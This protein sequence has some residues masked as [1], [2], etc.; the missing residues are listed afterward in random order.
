[1]Q[2]PVGEVYQSC[3]PSFEPHCGFSL[4]EASVECTE[5]C[6]CPGGQLRF[7]GKCVE[8]DA[9]PCQLRNKTF[10][11]HAH[12][13]RDCN[14]CECS[15]G[16]WQCSAETCGARCSA[17]GD[18]HYQTFDQRRFDFMGKCAYTLMQTANVSI[19]AENVACSGQISADIDVRYAAATDGKG[20]AV[21]QPSCTKSV[22]IALL[23]GD[24]VERVKL[25]QGR[26]VFVNGAPLPTIPSR[27]FGGRLKIREASSTVLSVRLADG[28]KVWWDGVTNVYID[29]PAAYRNQ[30][31]GLCGTFNSNA[32]DDFLTPE[33][34]TETAVEAF[35]NKWRTRESCGQV[36]SDAALP[37][38]CQLNVENRARARTACA[39]LRSEAF[40]SCDWYVG[41]EQFHADCM[42]DM[43]SCRTANVR[44]CLCP[45]LQ[46]YAS[47]CAQAGVPLQWRHRVA[48]CAVQCPAGQ[49]FEECGDSCHRTCADLH[50]E[51]DDDDIIVDVNNGVHTNDVGPS[52]TSSCRSACVE[53]CR[54]PRGQL[55]N[56]NGECV[57]TIQCACHFDGRP[58]SAG[59][60]EVRAGRRHLELCTCTNARW[61]CT[62]A[63]E[64]DAAQYPAAADKRKECAADPTRE[65][66]ECMPELVRTCKNMHQYAIDVRSVASVAA[67]A[68]ECRSGCVCRADRVWDSFK[69][70]CV[71]PTQCGC[72][73]GGKS[74]ETGQQIRSDCNTCECSSLGEWRCTDEPCP[75]T[76]VAWGD[77]H[78]ESF[79]G[80]DFDFQGVCSY[81]LSKGVLPETDDAFAISI[82]NVQCGTLG[83][84]CSKSVTIALLGNTRETITLDS[85][86]DTSTQPPQS[87]PNMLVYNVGLFTVVELRSLDVQVKWDRGTRVYIRLGVR[88]RRHVQG[89]CGNYNGDAEDDLKTPAAGV[90][91]NPTLFG[92]SWK[93]E[94]FCERPQEQI[95]TCAA[96]PERKLWAQ[97][98]C[99]ILKSPVFE[100]CHA[101]VSVDRFMRRCVYDSCGCDQ[102]GDCHCLCTAIAAY[103]HECA[104]KGVPIR[105]RTPQMCRKYYSLIRSSVDRRL[106]L[107]STNFQ[108]CNV[109][110]V[111]RNT[112]RVSARP[113]RRPRVT[114]AHLLA[115]TPCSNANR[116]AASKVVR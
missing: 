59:Y 40:A 81:L 23:N 94:E 46:A 67:P 61:S 3:G 105:W 57:P 70:L 69:Q 111:A 43:C 104:A 68:G 86:K 97:R 96:H 42:Y 74:F 28:L 50:A 41:V 26:A 95:D 85:A 62:K 83:V 84:T 66:V 51:D 13:R 33:G 58:Y 17:I 107:N 90:E 76:C 93:L 10:P 103:A 19:E 35:A 106:Y 6:F 63:S 112:H 9:C 47:Q 14:T 54:C 16:K 115:L 100:R 55:L 27:L 39:V 48:E 92:D 32:Q 99:G 31:A 78:F 49:V 80:R 7:E 64:S 71:T 102:G 116:V 73:H 37:D 114:T 65:F 110:S 56:D 53:G 98:Q 21:D 29:A 89:L 75:A 60:K 44:N 82:Q 11:A 18:P 77:S 91:A 1:M 5:G 20:S 24:R 34:D 45:V 108:P 88:W 25:L 30:T 79:D 113:V 15:L 4:N 12:I 38:A 36:D 109:T 22:T 101:E 2:C 87:T 72:H 52:P 8:L